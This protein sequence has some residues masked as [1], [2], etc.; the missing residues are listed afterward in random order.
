M[1]NAIESAIAVVT[2]WPP[3]LTARGGLAGERMAGTADR[4]RLTGRH[5]PSQRYV[6][7]QLEDPES[8]SLQHASWTEQ[9]RYSSPITAA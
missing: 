5:E 7:D 2:R 3:G 1:I 9:L 8:Q 4:H 6:I